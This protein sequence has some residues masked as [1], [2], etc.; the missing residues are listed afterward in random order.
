MFDARPHYCKPFQ[1]IRKEPSLVLTAPPAGWRKYFLMPLK[2]EANGGCTSAAR[3]Q[4]GAPLHLG[5]THA[6]LMQFRLP[7]TRRRLAEMAPDSH[8]KP[9][10]A[11]RVCVVSRIAEETP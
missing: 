9:S 2:P 4:T 10:F 11:S 7:F 6:C 5:A 1:Q 8:L 3:L